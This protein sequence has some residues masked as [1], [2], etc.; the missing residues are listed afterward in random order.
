MSRRATTLALCA[1]ICTVTACADKTITATQI[2]VQLDAQPGVRLKTHDVLVQV[3]SGQGEKTMWE[4]RF[5]KKMSPDSGRYRWPLQFALLPKNDDATRVY[6]VTATALDASGTE[7]ARVRA[8]SGYQ[9]HKVLLL[10][11]ILDDACI[12]EIT[13]CVDTETCRTGKC[14]D[15][16]VDVDS[17]QPFTD[18][19][20]GM[21]H[22]DIDGG[23]SAASSKPHDGVD[24]AGSGAG[25]G[26]DD[27]NDAGTAAASGHSGAGGKNEGGD[28]G[29]GGT[30]SVDDPDASKP[31]EPSNVD[32]S[33]I[34]FAS[35]PKAVLGCGDVTIDTSGS[36]T[37]TGWCGD[38]P[39]PKIRM[40]ES[41]PEIVILPL[42]SLT[43]KSGTTVKLTGPRAV[44]FVVDGDVTIAG[45][46]DASA[47][48]STPGPGG[49][50]ATVCAAGTGGKAQACSGSSIIFNGA[51]GGGFGSNGGAGGES[52]TCGAAGGPAGAINGDDD[53]VPLRG[54]CNGR[55]AGSGLGA[56]GGA[57]Q[58][59]S[60][61]ALTIESTGVV[62]AVG[63]G[64]SGM[65]FVALGAGTGG[66]SGG[67][68]LIE[69]TSVTND[70][71]VRAH[72]GGG[73]A[74]TGTGGQDGHKVD[75]IPALGGTSQGTYG[76]GGQGGVLCAGAACT[77]SSS[78]ATNGANGS[79]SGTGGGGG[80]GAGRIVI[81]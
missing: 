5:D 76:N 32:V 27:V 44:A 40:Q 18:D 31:F 75:D 2:M 50:D 80:G 66:G 70:G 3:R 12:G 45:T 57:V 14:V 23:A 36:V 26:Y 71:A 63:A 53:L 10:S 56:A 37:I 17:L 73:S 47:T 48:G 79:A 51:G 6:E 20:D 19:A 60:R 4:D 29:S 34:D 11:L 1:L 30:R 69:A 8:I 15:G 35:A 54:G 46:I 67:A 9:A 81:R 77:A 16:H 13:K 25:S 22:P 38:F 21:S 59:S 52:T 61:G 28:S 39:T 43:V 65:Q 49:G 41:G 42:K 72:G 78:A 33:T 68:V 24:N 64:G 58:I 74:G 62:L 7:F 55:S